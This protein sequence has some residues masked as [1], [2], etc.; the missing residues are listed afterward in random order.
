[1]IEI[2]SSDHSIWIGTD[3]FSKLELTKYS[4]VGILVDENT[5]KHCLPKFPKTDNTIIIEIKSGEE[6]KNLKTCEHIWQQLTNNEFAEAVK[7][8]KPTDFFP[9]LLKREVANDPNPFIQRDYEKCIACY[10]CTNICNDWEQASAITV[11]GRGQESKIFSFFDNKLMESNCTFCGQCINTCPTG[12]LSNKK[13][14]KSVSK[15]ETKT[16]TICPYCGVGCGIELI[17]NGEKILGSTPD[18][19]APSL[20]SLC[21]KGQFA[22]WDFVNSKERLTD[23]LL[24]NNKGEFEKVSWEKAYEVFSQKL[25]NSIDNHGPDSTVWW[26]SARV[27]TEANYLLQKFARTVVGTNNIDNCSRT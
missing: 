16:K 1:M 21:V 2:K 27:V 18:F 22:S 6:N 23:P 11:D 10:R 9:K 20:G 3:C 14:E 19:D 4:K 5:K 25:N 17:S 8:Y 15:P 7:E 13:I 12:A 24:K 26:A